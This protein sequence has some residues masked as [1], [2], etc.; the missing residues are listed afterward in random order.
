MTNKLGILGA[1]T[2]IAAGALAATAGTAVAKSAPMFKIAMNADPDVLDMTISTNPPQGFATM[3]NVYDSLDNQAPDGKIIPALA[4]SWDIKDGGKVIIFHLRHGVKFQSGDPMTAADVV[5]SHYRMLKKALFYPGFAR[6]VTK[7]KALGPYTVEYDFSQPDAQY[8]PVHPMIVA[9][10][11]YFDRV[12]EKEFEKHPVGTGPYKIVDYKP[13]Q[14]LDLST[15]KGYWGKQPQI[16]KARFYFVQ[17]ANTRVAKLQAGEVDMIMAT[18]Y[19]AYGQL[20]KA[21]FN[22]VKLPVHPTQSV[23][24]QFANMH[25]P[26]HDLRIRRAM[27][28]AI[29]KTAIVKGLLHG[30]PYHYPRLM[31]DELGYDPH[32]KQYKYNP[33]KAKALE[34]AA[35]YPHGFTMPLYV[36]TGVYYGTEE[37]ATAVALYLKQ[38]LNITSNLHD[39]QLI[40]L[41]QKIGAVASDPKAE[42]VAVAGLPVAN[43]PT[44]L[45]G[46]SLA[47]Y[48]KQ[49]LSLYHNS[50]LDKLFEKADSTLDLKKQAPLIKRIMAIEQE[51]LPTITLWQYVDV[52]AM[53]KNIHYTAGL[54]NLEIVYLPW[55]DEKM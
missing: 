26:W 40:Q 1:L 12:G 19:S 46:I 42:Y 33:A 53:K 5:W 25:D 48:G 10:K 39:L 52:Y 41:L 18:P 28:Y 54:H 31:P 6:F 45:E 2:V 22:L 16:K 38:N 50:E 30:V 3:Q 13:A 43:L 36:S 37:T 20:K 17:D 21:G 29:D 51:D 55:V 27:A 4:T 44:P 15:W 47:F 32:L 35:G 24:F 8:L 14:Y 7:V 49:R 23:Q 11:R 34:A 9:S